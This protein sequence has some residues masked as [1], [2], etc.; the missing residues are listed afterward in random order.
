MRLPQWLSDKQTACNAGD[1]GNM[2]LIPGSGRSSEEGNGSPF[3]YSC[4]GN[5]VDRGSWWATQSWKRMKSLMMSSKYPGASQEAPPPASAR[6][7]REAGSI[8]GQEDS[9]E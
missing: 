2:G 9:L 7:E 1:T 4:L 5:P 6:D 3:Q 8:P